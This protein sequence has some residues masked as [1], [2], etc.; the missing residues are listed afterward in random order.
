[1]QFTSGGTSI[2]V[3]CGLFQGSRSLETLN[4]GSFSFDPRDISA[5]VL[6][7]AHIDHSGLLPKLVK[8]GFK[9]KIWCT[10]ETS[11]LLEHMLADSGRIQE[12][13]TQR[14]N[15][16]R[17]RAGE[18]P[19][20]PV[21]TEQDAIAAWRRTRPIKLEEAFEPAPGFN[22]RLWNAGHILGSA[23]VELAIEGIRIICSGD[24]GPENKAFLPDPDGPKDFDYVVCESTYGDRER[25]EVT[26][27]QRRKLLEAEA[28]AAIARGGNLVIPAF[29]LERT[30]ELL[31]DLAYLERTGALPN[32]PV[33]VD[34]PLANN[35]TRVFER[36]YAELEDTDGRDIFRNPAFHYVDDVKESMRLNTLSGAI[37]M[38]A[39]GMCEG[40]RIRH[41]L[42]HNLHRREST[43][44][45]VGYQAQGTLGRVLLEGADTVRISGKDVR[46]RA[47]IRRIDSYSAHADQGEL[48]EWIADR[49]PVR[50]NLFLSHGEPEALEAMRRELQKIDPEL[51][52]RL[53]EIGESY[54][55]SS[56]QPAKRIKTGREDLRHALGRDWQNSYAQ[57]ITGLK[58]ELSHIRDEKQREKAIADMRK[59]LDSY[60][61]FRNTRHQRN[62]DGK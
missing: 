36:Y 28:K 31:L 18:E 24:V 43:V 21:Y 1:M 49:G 42:V 7:H 59:V 15:R 30:Q 9:G 10:P 37:I 34:S 41:H 40:G 6:T 32:V 55:L 14:R 26:I 50:G 20:E 47:Q 19:F 58:D 8:H 60:T 35:T 39:S 27:E 52:V 11:D 51:K 53:P 25:E 38:A 45:F 46:V 61:E 62:H 16:R 12:Y 56:G 22:A 48:L 54:A 23:S 2:L 5:V 17:D 44:L 29:A 3:D 13:D 4:A 33:F 57:F